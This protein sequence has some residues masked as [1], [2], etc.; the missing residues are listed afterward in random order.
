MKTAI[1]SII[2]AIAIISCSQPQKEVAQTV[3]DT[4]QTVVRTDTGVFLRVTYSVNGLETSSELRRAKAG[5]KTEAFERT[6]FAYDTLG[7]KILEIKSCFNA[8]KKDFVDVSKEE[9]EYDELNQASL[10]TYYVERFGHWH[11][12]QRIGR[13]FDSKGNPA[14]VEIY[15][16]RFGDGWAIKDKTFYKY[17]AYNNVIEKTDFEADETGEWHPLSK[18]QREYKKT[19][20]VTEIVF[21]PAPGNKW[22]EKT[23]AEYEY[24]A[25]HYC[26][27]STS[28][29]FKRGN[30]V[31]YVQAVYS[32]DASGNIKE[33][34]TYFWNEKTGRW[35]LYETEEF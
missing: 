21:E 35:K 8:E 17:D 34:E 1:I 26:T 10:S 20:L 25:S 27:K 24:N 13:T 2:I 23:K 18:F 6:V 4:L 11:P 14:T 31:N 3:C 22:A 32:F 12:K 33:C 5:G 16:P 28:Y 7:N 9:F 15:E 19:D 30:W 29:V